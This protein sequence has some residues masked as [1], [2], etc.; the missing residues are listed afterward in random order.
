MLAFLGLVAIIFTTSISI[1]CDRSGL[2]PDQCIERVKGLERVYEYP[3][4]KN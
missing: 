3:N 2:N 1:D 4:S